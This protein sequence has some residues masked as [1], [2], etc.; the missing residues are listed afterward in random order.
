MS[1]EKCHLVDLQRI[2]DARGHIGV[3]E[4]NQHIPFIVKRVYYLFGVTDGADRGSHAHKELQQL[5]IPLVGHF[6]ITLDDAFHSKTFH[7]NNPT[8]GLY[9]APGNWRVLKNFSPDA[10]CMVLA[11]E[12]YSEADYY[13]HYD[14]FVAAVKRKKTGS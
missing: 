14:D 12:N 1:L 7:L 2:S 9:I 8:Q 6:D 4:C 13:R 10:L 5:I 3:V 11:S